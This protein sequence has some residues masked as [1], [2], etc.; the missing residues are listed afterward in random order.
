MAVN[1][2]VRDMRDAETILAIIRERIRSLE[3]R[4]MR[5][6]Q[7]RFGG[8]PMEKVMS[9]VDRHCRSKRTTKRTPASIMN[10][11]SGLPYFAKIEAA[12]LFGRVSTLSERETPEGYAVEFASLDQDV[13]AWVES[14]SKDFAIV[15]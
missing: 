12:T 11:A 7:A 4:V 5:K 13:L 10:L 9:P 14:K 1:V 6:Y 2:K 3:S 8:G 15:W